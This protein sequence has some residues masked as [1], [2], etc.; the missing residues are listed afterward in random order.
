MQTL[1]RVR[2][3][4]DPSAWESRVLL[5][6][7][8]VVLHDAYQV[9]V[10]GALVLSLGEA[11]GYSSVHEV[12]K[13][14]H[15]EDHPVVRLLGQIGAVRQNARCAGKLHQAVQAGFPGLP[16]QEANVVQRVLGVATRNSV[17]C[18]FRHQQS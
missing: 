3:C 5:E 2:I 8:P 16:R 12:V 7:R 4:C 13:V 18:G 9:R 1:P 14:L 6:G 15:R 17:A 11:E 10:E